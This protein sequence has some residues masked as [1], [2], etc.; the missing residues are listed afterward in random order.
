MF[1]VR[2]DAP[3]LIV[4]NTP[5]SDSGIIVF[6]SG[7]NKCVCSS[8]HLSETLTIPGEW[9]PS[10]IDEDRLAQKLGSGKAAKVLGITENQVQTKEH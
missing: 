4:M 6:V 7:T 10:L 3:P 8:F 1:S 2:R 9:D 5:R